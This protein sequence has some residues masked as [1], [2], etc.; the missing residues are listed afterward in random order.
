MVPSATAALVVAVALAGCAGG[1]GLADRSATTEQS[2]TAPATTA[3]RMPS[4][5]PPDELTNETAKRVALDHEEAYVHDRLRTA[6]DVRRFGV[7]ENATTYVDA[8]VL[9]ESDG[10]V[11]VRVHMPYSYSTDS[12][13]ADGSTDAV[14]FVSEETVERVRGDEVSP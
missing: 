6:S 13:E 12:V 9:N 5:D 3:D 4:P 2:T 1:L 10:G 8:E 14:Y 11:Y 7:R